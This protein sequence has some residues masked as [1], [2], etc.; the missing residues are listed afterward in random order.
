MRQP[1]RSV[2]I[3]IQIVLV[4]L[5]TIF[6][7]HNLGLCED[8]KIGAIASLTGPAGE[9]GRNWSEGAQLAAE[10][11]STAE[12]KIQLIVEDDQTQPA[13]VASAFQKLAQL[14]HVQGLIA[15]TWDYL[16]EAAY[17]LAQRARLPLITPTNPVEIL[18]AGAQKN[19]YIF[20]NG[21]SLAAEEEVI[22]KFFIEQ[23]IKSV[24]IIYPNLPFGQLHAAMIKRII[25]ALGLSV[26]FDL[27]FPVEGA[28]QDSLKLGALKARDTQPDIVFTVIDYNGLDILT[29]EFKRLGANA[30]ILTT[31]HLDRA[32]EFSKDPARYTNVYAV[33]PMIKSGDFAAAYQ[34]KF[35]HPARVYAAEGYDACTFLVKLITARIDPA[36]S[37]ITEL[38]F[39][40]VTGMHFFPAKMRAVSDSKAIIMTTRDGVFAEYK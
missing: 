22:N 23:K 3:L 13:R 36:A 31:Q 28:Y 37:S 16:G 40:G 21:L 5:L 29:N 38:K 7:T 25:S 11:L 26:S 27:E 20:T 6:A 19:P 32:F 4:A 17:P 24:G 33:Y 8:I 15:G 35:G 9:Q 39:E 18:S 30:K 10:Q 14:D 34:K 2:I 1:I 12:T